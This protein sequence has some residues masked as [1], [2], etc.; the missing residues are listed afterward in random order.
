MGWNFFEKL[1]ASVIFK[2]KNPFFSCSGACEN[3]VAGEKVMKLLAKLQE[4]FRTSPFETKKFF[5]IIPTSISGRH[6]TQTVPRDI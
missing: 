1:F 6:F 4:K 3:V 5:L 2:N